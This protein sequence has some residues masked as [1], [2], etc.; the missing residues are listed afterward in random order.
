MFLLATVLL[1]PNR[2]RAPDQPLLR[3]S[4]QLARARAAGFEGLELW[5][6]HWHLA[7]AAER[8]ALVASPLPIRVFNTYARV[9][10]AED[11]GRLDAVIAAAHALSVSA[12]KFNVGPAPGDP[13]RARDTLAQLAGRL[14]RGTRLRCECH[15]GT[16]LETPEVAAAF[17]GSLD[18]P[19]E[20]IVH[21][22][23]ITSDR[24]DGWFS[25]CGP[26]IAELHV[27]C[28]DEAGRWSGISRHP[29]R[30]RAVLDHLHALGFS[31]DL[32]LEFTAGT[33]SD[34]ET[35]EKLWSAAEADA[36]FLQ[37]YGPS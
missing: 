19:V 18:L 30:S 16:W 1:E 33:H 8:A 22:F 7:N 27:Q 36:A 24:L 21:P 34:G 14:P 20:I 31:G 6:N 13:A 26:R 28:R 17:F 2:W 4:Q 23:A 10:V 35:P 5:E 11:A 29:E 25:L 32:T 37:N 15:P 9:D 3:A 12:L